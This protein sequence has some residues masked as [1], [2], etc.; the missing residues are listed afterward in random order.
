MELEL[1]CVEVVMKGQSHYAVSLSGGTTAQGNSLQ[2]QM[3]FK[4]RLADPLV[5][6]FCSSFSTIGRKYLMFQSQIYASPAV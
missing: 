1:V 2:L 3:P 4:D 5:L 6:F